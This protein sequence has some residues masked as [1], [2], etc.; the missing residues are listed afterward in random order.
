MNANRGKTYIGVY[1]YPMS[2]TLLLNVMQFLRY[3]DICID[4]RHVSK[5]QTRKPEN[6]RNGL[7]TILVPQKIYPY[8]LQL[9]L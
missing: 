6:S 8:M 2:S 1:R 9:F 4:D 7:F 5:L 3:C